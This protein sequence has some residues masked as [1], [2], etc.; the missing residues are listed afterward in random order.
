[1]SEFDDEPFDEDD[2][3]LDTDFFKEEDDDRPCRYCN[4]R[5]HI[6]V[7]PDSSLGYRCP[8]CVKYE[9]D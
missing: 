9:D 2:S 5:G 7:E 4:G 8:D 1:M 3:M 6:A